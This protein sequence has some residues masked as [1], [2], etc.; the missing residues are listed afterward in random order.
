VLLFTQDKNS[1]A[2]R[3]WQRHSLPPIGAAA[4]NELFR[5]WREEGDER[6]RERIVR[7]NARFAIKMASLYVCS[8]RS[9]DDLISDAMEGMCVAAERYNPQMG[10]RFITYA[11]WW[12]RQSILAAIAT[13]SRVVTFPGNSYSDRRRV[14]RSAKRLQK[15]LQREP[16][17]EELVAECDMCQERV[18]RAM[19]VGSHEMSLDVPIYADERGSEVVGADKLADPRP[20]QDEE[21]A[22]AELRARV[23]Q[24]LDCLS[25][26]L[27]RVMSRVY[28]LETGEDEILEDVGRANCI[29]RERTRKLRNQAMGILRV[30]AGVDPP[31]R[32]PANNRNLGGCIRSVLCM[33]SS[34]EAAARLYGMTMAEWQRTKLLPAQL[35]AQREREYQARRVK[36]DAKARNARLQL[37]APKV[38]ET[39]QGTAIGSAGMVVAT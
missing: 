30:L 16:T 38:P 31:R 12:I 19:S 32:L 20:L 2:M 10:H 34:D 7:H 26:R 14:E 15:Q 35:K 27:Q 8:Q 36:L 5:R 28:G 3:Y 18:E 33:V 23:G 37:D 22:D 39:A 9:I 24:W 6:A 1:P 21:C 29:T 17:R 4:T 11:V 13:Q 25:P